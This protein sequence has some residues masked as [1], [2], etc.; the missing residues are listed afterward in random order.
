[1]NIIK[2][3]ELAWDKQV[4]EENKW[5]VPVSH[6]E[7]LAAKTKIPKLLLTPTIPIPFDWM[8][9]VVDKNIL[10]LA[11]GGGQQGPLFAAMGA[12]VTVFDNSSAQL[13]RDQ[14]VAQREHLIIKTI[15]GDMKDLSCFQ[16]EEFDLIFHPVANCFV[17]KIQPVWN[18]AYRVLKKGGVLLS[19][20]ANPIIYIFDLEKWDKGEF[21]VKNHIPYSDYEQL[22]KDFLQ[23]QLDNHNTLEF[24][25]SLEDQINGQIK[26]GFSITGFYEDSAGGDILDKHIKTFIATKASKG[27]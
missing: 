19:G 27:R 21:E 22:P 1:M 13:A 2:H 23:F 25:H 9:D 18:E 14:E 12:N 17:D 24:G 6:E 4:S 3:N 20:F 5:T 26:A 8:G 10:C 16:D 11:C 7:V 15:Q